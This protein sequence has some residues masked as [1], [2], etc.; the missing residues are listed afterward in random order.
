MTEIMVDLIYKVEQFSGGNNGKANNVFVPHLFG[1]K[2]MYQ[3][4]SVR[5]AINFIRLS[6]RNNVLCSIAQS[7]T[8]F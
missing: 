3:L 4:G 2:E 7:F 5:L 1:K 6:V 8:G